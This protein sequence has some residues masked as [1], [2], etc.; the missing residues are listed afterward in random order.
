MRVTNRLVVLL[1]GLSLGVLAACGA[2]P[3]EE[4]VRGEP[5]QVD[6]ETNTAFC[7]PCPVSAAGKVTAMSRVPVV[8]AKTGALLC[9]ICDGGDTGYCGDGLC[10][11]SESCSSCSYDCGVCPAYCGDGVCNGSETCSSCSYDCGVCQPSTYCGDGVCNGSE[12]SASCPSDCGGSSGPA[13]GR[14]SRWCGKVNIHQTAGG[15]WAWD[16]DCTSG[17]DIGGLSYCQKF[18]PATTSIRQVS[19]TSKPNNVWAN[20]GCAQIVDD[21]DGDDEFECVVD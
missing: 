15:S 13:L 17:C 20:A 4:S 5:A 9:P 3:Q 18:W 8:D 14:F 21:Y 2:V 12:T 19:V 10:S 1:V 11:G 16:S 7:Y 6:P